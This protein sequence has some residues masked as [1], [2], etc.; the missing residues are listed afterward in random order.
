MK[1]FISM[2]CAIAMIFSM[3]ITG[4]A[5]DYGDEALVD[6]DYQTAVDVMSAIG[7]FNGNKGNLYPKDTLTRAEAAKVITYSL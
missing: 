2:L 7:V 5:A 6:A 1:K 3:A 4:F